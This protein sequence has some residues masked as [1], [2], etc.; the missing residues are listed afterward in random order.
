MSASRSRAT[1]LKQAYFGLNLLSF[2]FN[3]DNYALLPV[4]YP[5][6]TSPHF[7]DD[8]A[9]TYGWVGASFAIAAVFG[10]LI[11]GGWA[12]KRGAREPLFVAQ[13]VMICGDI[14]T[15]LRLN[16]I[17]NILAGRIVSGIGAGSRTCCLWYLAKTTTGAQRGKMIGTWYAAGML[18]MVLAPAMAAL[19]G[20]F[21]TPEKGSVLSINAYNA[22]AL[23]SLLLHIIAVYIVQRW[24][25]D[26]PE[27][28]EEGVGALLRDPSSVDGGSEVRRNQT[29]N[30]Q[31]E[32]AE[33]TSTEAR[34][35]GPP[36]GCYILVVCQF[37][38]VTGISSFE[39]FV[40]PLFGHRF[41]SP[42]WV[43]GLV[44][45]GI[46][47]VVLLSAIASGVLNE[48]CKFSER[49]IEVTG[50]IVFVFGCAMSFDWSAYI[51]ISQ[52]ALI[53][54]EAVSTILVAF[55]FTFAFTMQPSL[56]SKLIM[57]HEGGTL[58]PNMGKY[59][60]WLSMA[61]SAAK[62]SG[63]ILVGYGLMAR[64]NPQ[65]A[66]NILVVVV[67][68]LVFASAILFV[69]GW[70]RLYVP[71]PN[72]EGGAVLSEKYNNEANEEVA[73]D[74]LSRRNSIARLRGASS[75]LLDESIEQ[76]LED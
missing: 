58:I 27:H 9:V 25:Y 71:L 6:I 13:F 31:I 48:S 30:S 19:S 40:V 26:P 50:I 59:M 45:A 57:N 73:Y 17:W 66:I 33:A 44:F 68:S 38:M 23:S 64:A 18:G 11:F 35:T 7:A 61:A 75:W 5:R 12:D 69:C 52:G 4:L 32:S 76:S 49:S 55:G 22:P 60:A 10:S 16:S 53:A 15:Y 28:G 63:P 8:S 14:L 1:V 56:F 54:L 34:R 20:V 67:V 70:S 72:D 37:F 42:P 65:D 21:P 74:N 24:V 2:C 41:G 51:A 39:T 62:I 36:C 29:L 47:L 3:W 43:S 46:G